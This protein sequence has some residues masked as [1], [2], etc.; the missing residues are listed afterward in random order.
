MNIAIIPCFNVKNKI[1]LVLKKIP[2]QIDKIIIIDDCC[3]Q[4]TGEHV[5]KNFKSKK[6]IVLKNKKNLGVGG[7]TIVGYK[8]SKK[9]KPDLV[10]KIDGDNQ[11]RP[12]QI[13]KFLKIIKKIPSLDCLKGN[14]FSN[15]NDYK[16][17]PNLRYFGN[18][19]LTLIGKLVTGYY[20]INDFTNGFFCLTGR[21]LNK[22]N[23]DKISKD[24]FFENDMMIA[25]SSIKAK[26]SN[27]S[28][29]CSYKGNESNLKISRI[30]FP[31]IFKFFIGFLNKKKFIKKL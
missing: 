12:S 11:I 9:F 22:I 30:I 2:P 10:F 14:R 4:N 16:E 8:F 17:M 29:F 26:V 21:S 13:I 6:M 18:K 7:A 27:V 5:K 31:F 25:L 20:H 15:Y 28:T 19:V 24:F 23:L 1:L 3:P